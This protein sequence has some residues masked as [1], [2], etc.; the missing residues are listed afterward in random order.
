MD[1]KLRSKRLAP[2]LIREITRRVNLRGMWQAVYTAGVVLPKPVTSCRYWHRSIKPKKL[3]EVGFSR[4]QPR[5]TMQRT[6]RLYKLADKPSS[7]LIRPLTPSDVPSAALLLNESLGAYALRPVLSLEDV[8]HWLLPRKDVIDCF[9]I[10]KRVPRKQA[11]AAA[12]AAAERIAART[13]KWLAENPSVSAEGAV[14]GAAA[15][16]AAVDSVEGSL[17]GGTRGDAGAAASAAASVGESAAGG[18]AAAAGGEAAAGGA[19]AAAGG[20]AAA[21]GGEAAAWSP[22]PWY[23]EAALAVGAA[24]S[25]DE[26]V[27]DVVTDIVSFYHLPSTVINSKEGHTHLY[28][29]YLYYY[30]ATSVPLR[31]LLEDALILARDAGIDVFNCLDLMDNQPHLEP[32][33]F[34]IGDGNLQYYL[35]NWGA[36]SFSRARVLTACYNPPLLSA[37]CADGPSPPRLAA[38]P[39]MKP[40]QVGLVLH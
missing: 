26:E 32:L 31:S 21:A 33:K 25:S 38:C 10:S 18:A 15:A 12:R 20:A 9:V 14:A 40:G 5:M 7:A 3:I 27:V 11:V 8:A 23:D 22:T 1:K 19:A 35:F 16:A 4:L 29:A 6:E 34:G 30:A 37:H 28:A 39:S 36:L 17:G 13:R 2:V 24:A